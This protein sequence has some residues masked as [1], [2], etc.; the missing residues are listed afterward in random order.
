MLLLN[1]QSNLKNISG[2]NTFGSP[3]QDGLK[4]VS[5]KLQHFSYVTSPHCT[6]HSNNTF[7]ERKVPTASGWTRARDRAQGLLLLCE[8]QWHSSPLFQRRNLSVRPSWCCPSLTLQLGLSWGPL[9]SALTLTLG[10]DG[11]VGWQNCLSLRPRLRI[12]TLGWPHLL[13]P[14]LF[15]SSWWAPVGQLPGP[16]GHGPCQPCWHSWLALPLQHSLPFLCHCTCLLC[17]FSY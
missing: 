9:L 3:C 15:C 12:C 14:D 6:L 2:N 5:S 1:S 8:Q 13:S 17:I 10:H 4:P 16:W 11:L 7:Q